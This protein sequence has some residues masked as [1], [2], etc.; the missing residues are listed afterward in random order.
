MMSAIL[1]TPG[2]VTDGS[3]SQMNGNNTTPT[4]AVNK[5]ITATLLSLKKRSTRYLSRWT[6]MA[7]STG[8]EKAKT[9]QD[10]QPPRMHVLFGNQD[11][12]PIFP[13]SPRFACPGD[14]QV[15]PRGR[16]NSAFLVN[17][18]AT[19][20]N[21]TGGFNHTGKPGVTKFCAVSYLRTAGS[22]P[23]TPVRPGTTM[24][25]KIIAGCLALGTL[26]IAQRAFSAGLSVAP[27][28]KAP[29]PVQVIP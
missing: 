20:G 27:L 10:T 8:P 25:K 26:F 9:T 6:E 7:Q 19:R 16:R 14:A 4:K 24:M 21:E 12:T 28:Y 18:V 29:H 3:Y 1:R 13:A 11:V 22:K 15:R 5:S 17:T 23:P 2:A